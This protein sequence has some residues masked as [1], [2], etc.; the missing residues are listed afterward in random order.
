MVLLGV[1]LG[2]TTAPATESIMGS[3]S[4]DKAGVGSAVNDTTREL[5]GTLG[6]AIIGSVFSSIYIGALDERGWRVRPAPARGAGS[7]QGVGRRSALSSPPS[8]ARAPRLPGPGERRLP[9]GSRRRL[10]RRRRCGRCRSDLRQPSSSPPERDRHELR[11]ELCQAQLV[12]V[13]DRRVGRRAPSLSWVTVSSGPADSPRRLYQ[14]VSMPK[15]RAAA[16]VGRE[17]VADHDGVGL[18]RVAEAVRRRCRRSR[19]AAS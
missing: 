17:A 12:T 8:S 16:D 15:L 9:V 14:H 5:G 1:G 19:G 11:H 10:P 6:V 18:G 13:E 4:A 3:L 2:A 7:H